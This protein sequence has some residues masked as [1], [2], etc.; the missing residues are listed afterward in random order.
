MKGDKVEVNTDG[1]DETEQVY[2]PRV[3]NEAKERALRVK[4]SLPSGSSTGTDGQMRR[5]SVMLARAR[6]AAGPYKLS[7]EL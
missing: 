4:H 5:G 3:S 1:A 2:D 6:V 7:S